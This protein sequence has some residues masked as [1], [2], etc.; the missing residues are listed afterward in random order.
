M[1]TKDIRSESLEPVNVT[2][3]AKDFADVI[4]LRLVPKIGRVSWIFQ[5]G[6][7]CNHIHPY[8]REAERYTIQTEK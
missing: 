2:L 4:K 7:D 6:P 8:K 3:H 5:V 1:S